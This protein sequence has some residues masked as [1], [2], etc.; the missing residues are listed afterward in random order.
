MD[1]IAAGHISEDKASLAVDSH[2]MKRAREGVMT[3]AT[4]TEDERAKQE[5]IRA[6]GYDGRK[7]KTRAMV[8]DSSGRLHPRMIKEEHISVTAEPS[9]RYL[10]HFTPESAVHPEKPAKLVAKGL[11]SILEQARALET[12]DT[13]AGDSY[14]GNTGWKGG[15]NAHLERMLGRKLHWAICLSHTNELPLRHL[16]EQLDGKTSS[17]D[18]FTGPIGKLLS[19][20]SFYIYNNIITNCF[21]R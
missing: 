8:P 2:K 13:V 10:S 18:G 17:K 15:S 1:L 20:V 9:G 7:D 21:V 14:N 5:N 19:K 4:D 11:Y 6:I 12:L 16:I 3:K